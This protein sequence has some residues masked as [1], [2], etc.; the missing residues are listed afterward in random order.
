MLISIFMSFLIF[1]DE[2]KNR[3]MTNTVAFGLPEAKVMAGKYVVTLIVAFIAFV[4]VEAVLV[5]S[6]YLLLGNTGWNNS[7]DG[8]E[9]LRQL[10]EADIACI[11]L[12]MAGIAIY[13]AL[14]FWMRNEM[15][16]VWGWLAGVA[17]VG[18]VVGLLG[19]KFSFFQKVEKI[20]IYRLVG[21]Y[22]YDEENGLR[23]IWETANGRIWCV[24]VG[25]VTTVIFLA[26]AVIGSRKKR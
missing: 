12:F 19:M 6:A 24:M 23:L 3:T 13:Y 20:L 15:H 9:S 26:L 5:I 1:A 7:A 10:L 14:L 18:Q 21:M 25:L 22:D 2:Y 17:G 11:P 4:V 16:A 8:M